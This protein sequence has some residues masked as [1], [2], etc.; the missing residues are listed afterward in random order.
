MLL[1][2]I[3]EQRPKMS[4]NSEDQAA[5]VRL[6]TTLTR[7]LIALR[8][9]YREVASLRSLSRRLGGL[10]FYGRLP[11]AEEGLLAAE[12][13]DEGVAMALVKYNNIFIIV[14]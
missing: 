9:T 2:R 14:V 6:Q 3:F 11:S 4:N 7:A 8:V 5:V 13:G 1:F 10:A 12:V